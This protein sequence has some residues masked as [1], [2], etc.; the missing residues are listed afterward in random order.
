[1]LLCRRQRRV[2]IHGTCEAGGQRGHTNQTTCEPQATR[3][4]ADS[5]FRG[6]V[7]QPFTKRSRL[8]DRGRRHTPTHAHRGVESKVKRK[9]YIG[10]ALRKHSPLLCTHKRVATSDRGSTVEGVA[11]KYAWWAAGVERTRKRSTGECRACALARIAVLPC[12]A[13][14]HSTEVLSRLPSRE[15]VTLH[16][17]A[18]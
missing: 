13:S 10:A 7:P 11:R 15:C 14:F 1:M 3:N 6:T 18:A 8:V 4:L 5:P 17:A 2:S 16:P 12:S 9:L